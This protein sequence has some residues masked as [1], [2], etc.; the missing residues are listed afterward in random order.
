MICLQ[1]SMNQ[2][3]LGSVSVAGKFSDYLGMAEPTNAPLFFD[4]H[5]VSMAMMNFYKLGLR[6]PLFKV[7]Y[8]FAY[9]LF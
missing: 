7:G 4:E 8:R 3:A 2:V 1:L 9:I 6:R 5:D